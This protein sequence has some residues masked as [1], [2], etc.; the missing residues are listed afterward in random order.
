MQEYSNSDNSKKKFK[1]SQL[2]KNNLSKK[3]VI[4]YLDLINIYKQKFFFPN[5]KKN[6][7]VAKISFQI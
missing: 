7:F 5:F 4:S 1:G 6:C 3:N 2:K